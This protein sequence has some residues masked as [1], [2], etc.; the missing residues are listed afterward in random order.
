MVRSA[1]CH[2]RWKHRASIV[3]SLPVSLPAKR[4]AGPLPCALSPHLKFLL[5]FTS[6]PTT[7]TPKTIARANAP[8]RRI[9]RFFHL[10]REL[11]NAIYAS[12]TQRREYTI[13]SFNWAGGAST[14]VVVNRVTIPD[15]RLVCRRFLQE[16]EEEVIRE[17]ELV[18]PFAMGVRLYVWE[19]AQRIPAQHWAALRKVKLQISADVHPDDM[20]FTARDDLRDLPRMSPFVDVNRDQLLIFPPSEQALDV[21]QR[22]CAPSFWTSRTTVC[23]R[24]QSGP[25]HRA[26]R[27]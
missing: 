2:A 14:I 6:T 20:A 18:V 8:H 22:L 4:R 17:S 19:T 9:F 1:S 5:E 16:Y 10:P 21:T 24:G 23:A 13:P 26:S 27:R 3:P 15:L 11:R 12:C 25:R 7:T